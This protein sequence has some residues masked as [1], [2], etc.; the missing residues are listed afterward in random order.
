MRRLMLDVYNVGI[1]NISISTI[2]TLLYIYCLLEFVYIVYPIEADYVA[3]RYEPQLFHPCFVP[4]MFCLLELIHCLPGNNTW[5]H[6]KRLN[7]PGV[8][9]A[10]LGHACTCN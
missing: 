2:Y 6:T 9:F 4:S 3:A 10:S 8:S 1:N 5:I 7:L